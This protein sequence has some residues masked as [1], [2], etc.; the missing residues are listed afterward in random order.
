MK[1]K[2]YLVASLSLFLTF[3]LSAGLTYY[4]DTVSNDPTLCIVFAVLGQVAI[5]LPAL[6]LLHKTQPKIAKLTGGDLKNCNRRMWSMSLTMGIAMGCATWLLRYVVERLLGT[7]TFVLQPAPF[8][9]FGKELSLGWMLLGALFCAITEELFLRGYLQKRLCVSFGSRAV[10][11]CSGVAFAILAGSWE[12]FAGY[13]LA[14]MAFAWLA[15]VTGTVVSSM[16]GHFT[17]VATLL[18][19]GELIDAFKPY[20]IWQHIAKFVG[21]FGLFFWYWFLRNAHKLLLQERLLPLQ[22]KEENHHA[23]LHIT[24]NI[25]TIALLFAFIAKAVFGIL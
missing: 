15:V 5:Y 21:L 6:V 25:G 18:V 2:Q 11:G 20:G 10:I 16:A 22:F 3:C 23:F 19:I 13:L 14:G 9:V 8:F 7:E 17:F 24:T 1:A 12:T 4:Y